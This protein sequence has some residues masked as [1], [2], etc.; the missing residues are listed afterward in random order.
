MVTFL[1]GELINGDLRKERMYRYSNY[2]GTSHALLKPE[3]TLL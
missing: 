3:Q 2:I 1:F